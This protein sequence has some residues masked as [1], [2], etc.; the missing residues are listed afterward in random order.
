MSR[1][2]STC[3]FLKGIDTNRCPTERSLPGKDLE[4]VFSSYVQNA[5]KLAKL[6]GSQAHESFNNIVASK[7]PKNMHFSGF[8]SLSY[9]VSA[10][11]SQKNDGHTYITR[12][13]PTKSSSMFALLICMTFSELCEFSSS[14]HPQTTPIQPY[15]VHFPVS[16]PS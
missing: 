2:V 4:N 11:V 5:E 15:L 1:G 9:R 14:C 8:E 10:A 16:P 3:P 13:S 6:E 12:V 7:A